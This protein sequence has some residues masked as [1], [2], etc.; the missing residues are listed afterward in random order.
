MSLLL[1]EKQNIFLAR[2]GRGRMWHVQTWEALPSEIITRILRDSSLWMTDC[3][4]SVV[5]VLPLVCKLWQ[6]TVSDFCIEAESWW[7]D[8]FIEGGAG[9]YRQ[10][11]YRDAT[12]EPREYLDWAGWIR[13]H[14]LYPE[15]WDY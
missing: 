8:P 13:V 9:M 1:P 12:P 10:G 7:R 6:A 15:L 14:N 2:G 11:V 3:P 5:R 4:R